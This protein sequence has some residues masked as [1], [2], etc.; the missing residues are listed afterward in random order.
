MSARIINQKGVV[1]NMDWLWQASIATDA[2]TG[3][4]PIAFTLVTSHM[5]LPLPSASSSKDT[6]TVRMNPICW[7]RSAFANTHFNPLFM[8]VDILGAY[9]SKDRYVY[10]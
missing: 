8:K 1:S 9:P 5:C 6:T 2:Q 3:M 7:L 10:G 4:Y